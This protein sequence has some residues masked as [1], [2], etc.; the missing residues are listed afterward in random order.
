MPDPP[1]PSGTLTFLLTDVEGSTDIWESDPGRARVAFARHDALVTEH[2]EAFGGSRPRDQG[3]GDSAL[4][5]FARASDA[6][7]CAIVLQ[8]SLHAEPWPAGAIIRVR[9][10]LHTGEAELANDNYKGSAVHRCARLRGLAHGGQVL[11]SDA[12]AQLV[13]DHLPRDVTL[14]DMGTHELRGL[15]HAEHTFQVCVRDLPSEFPPLK[16]A[17]VG[18]RDLLVG[19]AVPLPPALSPDDDVFV[20]RGAELAALHTAWDAADGLLFVSG[21][22]GIGKSRLAGCFAAEVH[23]SDATVL[24]GRCDEEALRPHQPFAEALSEYLRLYPDDELQY[25]LGRSAADLAR[26]LP[27]LTDRAPTIEPQTRDTESDRFRSFDALAVFL[28]ELGANARVLLVLDD[29][30]WA[31]AAT[32][33]L[34]RHVARHTDPARVTMLAT[35]RQQ[36]ESARTPFAST[37]VDLDREHRGAHVELTGLTEPEV[38]ALLGSSDARAPELARVLCDETGG[39]PFFIH[40]VLRD[41][42]ERG[43]TLDPDGIAAPSRVRGVVAQRLGR[44]PT[45]ANR[46]LDAASVIGRE[47]DIDLLV[48]M[49]ALGEDEMLDALDTAVHSGIIREL[50]TAVGRYAFA[51]AL[52]R[53]TLYEGL[54]RTRRARLHHRVAEGIES[55]YADDLD[56]QLAVLAYHCAMA[57]G[58]ADQSKAVEYAWRAGNRSTRLLAFEDAGRQYAAALRAIDAASPADE[59]RRYDLLCAIGQTAWRTNDVALARSSFLAAANHARSLGDPDRV[60]EAVLGCGGSGQRPWWTERGLVDEQLVEL[61]E[62]SLAGVGP[63]DRA[64]RVRVLGALAQQI[65]LVGQAGRRRSLADEAVATARRLNDEATLVEALLFWQGAVWDISNPSERLAVS[66]E[67][68]ELA[69]TLGLDELEMH[70]LMFR[71]VDELEL[72]D[73]EA[74]Y[75]DASA[76]GTGAR[77]RHLPFYLWPTMVFATMRALFEG[78]FAEAE[79]LIEDAFRVGLPAHPS[80]LRFMGAQLALLRRDQGR[81]DEFRAIVNGAFDQAVDIPV[82]RAACVLADLETGN[83]AAARDAFGSIAANSFRD[84]HEDFFAG[85]TLALLAEVCATLEDQTSAAAL[86]ELLLPARGRFMVLAIG[87]ICMGSTSHYLGL[88]ALTRG[89]WSDAEELL[90]EAI[91][92]HDRVGALPMLT[93]S[94]L[95]YLRLLR[96]RD[97]PGDRERADSLREQVITDAAALG[98]QSVLAAARALGP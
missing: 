57:G 63:E 60:A 70:A 95:A 91:E 71:V 47:F 61:L 65:F 88:L 73:F 31:D 79:D 96:A 8:R 33:L 15:H 25:R 76:L 34:L 50:P 45:D 28:S 4:A 3:E 40:E 64:I 86:C 82:W 36:P 7:G 90:T 81:P 53:Q 59:S 84:V 55:Q 58:E 21:E 62:E 94:R 6:L 38:A 30:Q 54:T 24:F 42:A 87:V 12:T 13:R 56:P 29:L 22:P 78:R 67:A 68:L 89:A 77:E 93:R 83:Q 92:A 74:A 26:L 69:R 75:A 41:V 66:V 9:M 19:A 43:S 16:S 46:V 97:A 98:M 80:A 17:S 39:N 72:G 18:P 23:S 52:L 32:L 2:L 85:V 37:L 20:G 14:R 49:T 44:L 5:V 11:L 10:A 48:A 51:H 35:Y 1:L 27:E